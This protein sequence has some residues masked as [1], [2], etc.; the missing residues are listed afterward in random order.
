[1][2]FAYLTP[3]EAA[4]LRLLSKK[5]AVVGLQYLVPTVHLDLKE[6]SFNQLR[7]IANH[8]VASKHVYELVYEVDRLESLSWE[9][10]SRRI[11]GAEYTASRYQGPP[12]P[13]GA[14]ASAATMHAY[15]Q[16]VEIYL[17]M[18]VY[19]FPQE[20]IRQEWNHFRD[21]YIKQWNICHSSSLAEKLRDALIKLPKLR[22]VRTSSKNT[23]TRWMEGFT[24]RS[25]ALWNENALVLDLPGAA[26]KVGLCS[27]QNVLRAL[28]HH[29][30]P[31]TT[32]CLDGLNWQF[33]AQNKKDFMLTKGCFR[34]LKHLS[35]FF[36]GRVTEL[37]DGISLSANRYDSDA[38]RRVKQR[39]RVV[40]LLS[41]APDLEALGICFGEC[42]V[43]MAM[44]LKHTFGMF[45]WHSLK[46]I[47]L[48]AFETSENELLD[49]FSRHANSLQS[50]TLNAIDLSDGTWLTTLHRMRQKMKLKH[51]HAREELTEA[52]G[53][54]FWV[55]RDKAKYWDVQC[56]VFYL[57]C[58]GELIGK[59]LQ[60]HDKED[61]TFEAYLASLRVEGLALPRVLR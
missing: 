61:M 31:I 13:P 37:D 1:M 56:K 39:G 20:Q 9:D 32:L 4:N 45:H 2:I 42:E 48:I 40:E 54:V 18:S 5:M 58:V 7:N 36:I 10:W 44:S 30:L 14:N 46:A 26:W 49:F 16:E 34:H 15:S 6:D 50:I 25:G 55:M 29:G 41:A 47:E 12:E 57:S 11:M 23:M 19:Q 17:S 24:Q 21:A 43:T 28:G 35:I 53:M 27:T 52:N 59:Y 33:L 38:F 51:V 8:P 22:S 60:E 3:G